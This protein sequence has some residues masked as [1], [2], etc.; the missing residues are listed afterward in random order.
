MYKRQV[1]QSASYSH[2]NLGPVSRSQPV[3]TAHSSN[4]AHSVG[5]HI[6][7]VPMRSGSSL[8]APSELLQ[9]AV[10]VNPQV[11][12]SASAHQ[13]Q[14]IVQ[15]DT[16][17]F[18]YQTDQRTNY[19]EERRHRHQESIMSH[20]PSNVT[21]QTGPTPVRY[22]HS[23]AQ[24]LPPTHRMAS[25]TVSFMTKT[26]EALNVIQPRMDSFT[27]PQPQPVSYTHLTLPTTPYV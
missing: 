24:A 26:H 16:R 11:S 5:S 19:L 8:S 21:I 3:I 9:S 25:S 18:Q 7:Q 14:K 1:S 15:Q 17:E 2:A 6:P 10:S 4:T 20:R 12:L 13:T 23:D 27:Q 22:A